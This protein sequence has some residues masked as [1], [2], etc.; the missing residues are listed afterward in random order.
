MVPVESAAQRVRRRWALRVQ[1]RTR[2][3]PERQLL[4]CVDV[5]HGHILP[6]HWRFANLRKIDIGDHLPG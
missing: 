1:T 2:V 5:P 6:N 3:D 4:R